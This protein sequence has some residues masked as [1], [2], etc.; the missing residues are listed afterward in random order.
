MIPAARPDLGPA[1]EDAVLRVIRS[2]MIAQGPEVEAFEAEF[3][4]GA[5]SGLHCVAVNSGTSALHLILLSLGIGPGDEVVVPS[6]TFAATANAVALTGATP[7]FADI[8]PD[9]YCL[10][11]AS[12]E[13]VVTDRTR[14]VMP[15]HL[16]GH[17]AAMVQL[18]ELCHRRGLY[19]IED[20]AQAHLAALKDRLVGT[21]GDAAAFSFYPTKNMTA[22]EGGMIVTTRPEVFARARMLRNQGQERRY[23]N[24]VVGLNNR[25]TDIHAAIGRVQLSA[26]QDRTLKRQRNAEFLTK[27]LSNVLTPSVRIG[28]THVFHQYTIRVRGLDRDRFSEQLAGAGVGSGVYY[29]KPVHTLPAFGHT[30][31]LPVTESAAREVLSLPVYPSL[32]QEDL[33]VIVASVNKL[34]A[35]GA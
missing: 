1:E 2:G 23:H 12:V 20:A 25:M 34:A 24:E 27:H 18:T 26:L 11:P 8:E 9:T 22:G 32:T 29:P 33:E 4:Q 10:S 15:V 30:Q 14:A 19:L 31:A 6:F 5:V 13:E 17:P 28:A 35:A 21:W 7:V 3:S 16:Y